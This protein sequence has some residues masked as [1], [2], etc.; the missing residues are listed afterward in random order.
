MSSIDKT[1]LTV[2]EQCDLDQVEQCGVA[3]SSSPPQNN[4]IGVDNSEEIAQKDLLVTG[5]SENKNP[6]KIANHGESS[7]LVVIDDLDDEITKVKAESFEN[8][9]SGENHSKNIAQLDDSDTKLSSLPAITHADDMDKIIQGLKDC[10]VNSPLENCLND[11]TRDSLQ[12]PL[13]IS[14]ILDC[15]LNRIAIK[16]NA[17]EIADIPFYG[18]F[19]MFNSEYRLHKA[20]EAY[21]QGQVSAIFE[22]CKEQGVLKRVI[23]HRDEQGTNP[24]GKAFFRDN[25]HL[26][27]CAIKMGTLFASQSAY[28]I[29]GFL[30]NKLYMDHATEPKLAIGGTT[31]LQ[32]VLIVAAKLDD[33]RLVEKIKLLKEFFKKLEEREMKD[34]KP[35]FPSAHPQF[36]GCVTV[37][38]FSKYKFS[39]D[40]VKTFCEKK[41]KELNLFYSKKELNDEGPISGDLDK[42]MLLIFNRYIGS[43]LK[44]ELSKSE[45][46]PKWQRLFDRYCSDFCQIPP[47]VQNFIRK[48]SFKNIAEL[49]NQLNQTV[50]D[51]GNVRA[52]LL[53]EYKDVLESMMVPLF[54]GVSLIQSVYSNSDRRKIR[55]FIYKINK[56]LIQNAPLSQKEKSFITLHSR[57]ATASAGFQTLVDLLKAKDEELQ[58]LQTIE[59]D[60]KKF[61]SGP[62]TNTVLTALSSYSSDFIKFPTAKIWNNLRPG[63]SPQ[64]SVVKS[65]APLL[66]TSKSSDHALRFANGRML[67]TIKEGTRMNPSYK[68]GHPKHR[69]TGLLFVTLHSLK[70]IVEGLTEGKIVDINHTFSKKDNVMRK[71]HQQECTFLDSIDSSTVLC[72]VPIVW[73]DILNRE[74]DWTEADKEYLTGVFSI[75][76]KAKTNTNCS[77][78]CLFNE[79]NNQLK[80]PKSNLSGTEKLFY[81]SF[82]NIGNGMLTS[83]AKED[84]KMLVTLLRDHTLIPYKVT[85]SK[86]KNE[87]FSSAQCDLQSGNSPD[88][89]KEHLWKC[90]CK[91]MSES[92][93]KEKLAQASG[94]Y[95][96]ISHK[97]QPVEEPEPENIIQGV[98]GVKEEYLEDQHVENS[99]AG[100]QRHTENW[101]H[102]RETRERYPSQSLDGYAQ[103][104]RE[105][106]ERSLDSVELESSSVRRRLFQEETEDVTNE[107][108]E[109]DTNFP[110]EKLSLSNN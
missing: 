8:D 61:I 99:H 36:H 6:L 101:Q 50:F 107:E 47:V 69:L 31:L 38:M 63:T 67:E 3:E 72:I 103:D 45:T 64:S 96:A 29:N 84:G 70:E 9:S 27:E 52:S 92:G 44:E 62:K 7:N 5:S 83:K 54:H 105:T 11:E 24:I 32:N 65:K 87:E 51:S 110:L 14:S 53:P 56:K 66:S 12:P 86:T 68:D 109:S 93:K 26:F 41:F 71:H 25:P 46:L 22:A 73:P 88:L 80:T 40:E 13:I 57:T 102:Y 104:W 16:F 58:N 18:S 78:V 85:W 90:L 17:L 100:A 106:G 15:Y 42:K 48:K 95:I 79:L 49:F 74:A 33:N 37:D 1:S 4:L 20:V 89:S 34:C 30:N 82:A 98:D 39:S 21:D 55:R 97:E 59:N 19:E 94:Q 10:V 91:I 2:T 35:N 75:N 28:N 43:V 60:L 77:P 23:N 108:G 76:Q 81:H